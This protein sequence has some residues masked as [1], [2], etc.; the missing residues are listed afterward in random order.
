M[1]D[2][3]KL[4]FCL[5]KIFSLFN[6]MILCMNEKLMKLLYLSEI[7]LLFLPLAQLLLFVLST[8]SPTPTSSVVFCLHKILREMA[9]YTKKFSIDQKFI[10]TLS[11]TL[12]IVP[13]KH[14]TQFHLFEVIK[15]RAIFVVMEWSSEER[16]MKLLKR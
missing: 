11:L 7:F 13:T 5:R 12:S 15:R 4:S 9:K 14:R 3:D 16:V 8:L 2:I 10:Q 6:H 1:N